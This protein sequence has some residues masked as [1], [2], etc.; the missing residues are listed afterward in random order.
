MDQNRPVRTAAK[1][2]L[3]AYPVLLGV[4]AIVVILY[5]TGVLKDSDEAKVNTQLALYMRDVGEGDYSGAC[6]RL[7][8]SLKAELGGDCAAVLRQR[9][10]GLKTLTGSTISRLKEAELDAQKVRVDGS[11]ATVADED[12]RFADEETSRDSKTG[13]SNTTV[14]Y[15]AA[16]DLTFGDGFRLTKVGDDW[17]VAGI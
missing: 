2:G 4:V 10:G 14:S 6:G 13:K 1:K 7:A 15:D 9:Y 17:K 11:T 12:L 8:D 5:F 16:P 3:W